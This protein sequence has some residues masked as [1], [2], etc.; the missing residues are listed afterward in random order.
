MKNEWKNNQ[1]NQENKRKVCCHP[2]LNVCAMKLWKTEEAPTDRVNYSAL[3][4]D[5]SKK[6]LAI[7]FLFCSSFFIELLF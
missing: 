5:Y 2:E 6:N 3:T 4:F 1:T 7:S